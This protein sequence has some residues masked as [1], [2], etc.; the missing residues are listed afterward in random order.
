MAN[1]EKWNKPFYKSFII[2]YLQHTLNSETNQNIQ[3]ENVTM[4][5]GILCL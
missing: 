5:E 3:I 1:N 4:I 2:G